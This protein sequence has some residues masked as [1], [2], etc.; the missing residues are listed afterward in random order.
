[1]LL[2]YL[3]RN[4]VYSLSL[5]DDMDPE[6]VVEGIGEGGNLLQLGVGASFL[7]RHFLCLEFEMDN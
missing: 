3:D 4:S 2:H 6:T 1:M 7:T 5:Y